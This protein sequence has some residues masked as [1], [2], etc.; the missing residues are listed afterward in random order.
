MTEANEILQMSPPV[1]CDFSS[2][3]QQNGKKG[4]IKWIIWIKFLETLLQSK[5]EKGFFF[6]KSE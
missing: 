5:I 4:K 6:F 3:L 2:N 1:I